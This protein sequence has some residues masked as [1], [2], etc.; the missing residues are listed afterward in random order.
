MSVGVQPCPHCDRDVVIVGADGEL[1]FTVGEIRAGV[2]AVGRMVGSTEAE[3]SGGE[4][5]LIKQLCWLRANA[6]TTA[7]QQTQ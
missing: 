6:T 3:A 2:Q 7:T 1:A 5:M 4:D